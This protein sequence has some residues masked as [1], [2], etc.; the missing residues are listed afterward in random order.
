MSARPSASARDIGDERGVVYVEF[1]MA[2]MPLFMLFLGICQLAL[3]HTARLVVQLAAFAAVRSAIVVLEE[4]PDGYDGAE[5]GS[6]SR[7]R[8]TDQPGI[9]SLLMKLGLLPRSGIPGTAHGLVGLTTFI[10]GVE[11]RAAQQGAR[12]SP[13]REAAYM[14]VMVLAP[15]DQTG[16]LAG[17]VDS[18]LGT[19]VQAALEFLESGE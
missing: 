5:R 13:I 15:S 14:P 8:A 16:T 4:S 7:G 17:S 11:V 9:D 3:M 10:T 2:F 19:R 12:M 1:L 6:L 18:R